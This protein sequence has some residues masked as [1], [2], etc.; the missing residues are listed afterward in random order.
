M[1]QCVIPDSRTTKLLCIE[2]SIAVARSSN[3][4]LHDECTQMN[5]SQHGR[6]VQLNH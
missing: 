1:D 3:E 2:I 4:Q 6:S 5:D